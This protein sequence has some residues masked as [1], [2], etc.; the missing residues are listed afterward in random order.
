MK[1]L[2]FGDILG[3]STLSCLE[4]NMAYIKNTYKPNIILANAENVTKG[5]GLSYEHYQ[6]L[7]KLGFQGLSMGNHT[8][9][10]S[11][12]KDYINDA[13]ICRPANFFD[14]PGKK[15][16]NINYNGKKITIVNLLGRIY[17]NQLC[18]DCPF[19][20]MDK[21]LSELDSDYIIVDF[22]AEATS[23]KIA[24]SLDFDGKVAA[25][26]GTHTHVQTN[27]ARVLQNGTLAI[28]DIGMCGPRDGVIGDSK[29]SI[30]NRFRSGVFTPCGVEGGPIQINAVLLDF[31]P[32]A[33]KITP[34]HLEFKK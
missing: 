15:Y 5:K 33:R 14:A 9:S 32:T 21:I 13:N 28:T 22:H 8:Y 17:M 26:L 24:F 10:K 3:E 4:E 1:I 34:I 19:Q 18:L 23:E 6:R 27:D 2:Y 31:G 12:I 11:E 20:T 30:I 25:I 29:D 7:M 16:L